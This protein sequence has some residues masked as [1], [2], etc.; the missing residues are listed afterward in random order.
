VEVIICRYSSGKLPIHLPMLGRGLVIR[1]FLVNTFCVISLQTETIQN[2]TISFDFGLCFTDAS[3]NVEKLNNCMKSLMEHRNDIYNVMSAHFIA[4]SSSQEYTREMSEMKAMI[5]KELGAMKSLIEENKKNAKQ[6]H[7]SLQDSLAN[8]HENAKQNHQSLQDSLA[9]VHE[10]INNV[11]KDVKNSSRDAKQNHQSLQDSLANVHEK[12]NNVEKDVK[13]SS[14]DKK[15]QNHRMIDAFYKTVTAIEDLRKTTIEIGD[16]QLLLESRRINQFN[17]QILGMLCPKNNT[18]P[19]ISYEYVVT[20]E[21]VH[22]PWLCISKYLLTN[23]SDV[24]QLYRH[25]INA[26]MW[27]CQCSLISSSDFLNLPSQFIQCNETSSGLVSQIYYTVDTFS[28][29]KSMAMGFTRPLLFQ[30][31][32]DQTDVMTPMSNSVPIREV[33]L[34][35]LKTMCPKDMTISSLLPEYLMTSESVMQPLQCLSKYMSSRRNEVCQL[36]QLTMNSTLSW[37]CECSSILS[38]YLILFPSRYMQCNKTLSNDRNIHIFYSNDTVV[39]NNDMIQMNTWKPLL[40]YALDDRSS[41]RNLG[42]LH[43]IDYSAKKT[44]GEGMWYCPWSDTTNR[45]KMF[46]MTLFNNPLLR[47]VHNLTLSRNDGYTICVWFK[48]TT[49]ISWRPLLD[50]AA[51]YIWTTTTPKQLYTYFNGQM[52]VNN[53]FNE[54]TWN[55][56]SV[57]VNGLNVSIWING[58]MINSG[59]VGSITDPFGSYFTIGHRRDVDDWNGCLEHVMIF[60][61]TLSS[62]EMKL[63]MSLINNDS[64]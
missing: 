38:R 57:V 9:N 35:A 51:W 43:S 22:L 64:F 56:L 47:S 63:W 3:N 18:T 53:A 32:E 21:I 15:S 11:E 16:V 30:T 55:Y 59:N 7:Q 25:S 49:D 42:S 39:W 36:Y 33:N 19:T 62:H 6:N 5:Q 13:N 12:I 41:V 60:N 54:G 58:T 48:R 24:C 14:R 26:T 1:L 50:G 31:V 61:K 23:S 28:D 27:T 8:V 37:M 20:T 17:Q 10:K 45:P 40:F 44:N 2:N 4:K 29:S 46:R 34:K 52:Y